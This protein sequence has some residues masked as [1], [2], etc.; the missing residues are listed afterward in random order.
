M[1]SYDEMDVIISDSK[2]ELYEARLYE[3][4]GAYYTAC[5]RVTDRRPYPGE[6]SIG[7]LAWVPL[8]RVVDA[9]PKGWDVLERLKNIS[10]T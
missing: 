1:A 2:G 7:R 6:A 5:V 8:V 3:C 9:S 4:N 10:L